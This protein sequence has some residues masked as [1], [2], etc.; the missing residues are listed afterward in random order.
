MNYNCE[1]IKEIAKILNEC[2]NYYDE[3]GR[4]LGNKCSYCEHW[5][6]TN[7]TCCSYNIKEA[8]ELYNAGYRKIPEGSVVLNR[9]EAQHYY[10]YKHIEPQIKGCLDRERKL[11]KQVKQERKETIKDS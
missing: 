3:Q 5:C 7:H 6:K 2:C 8:E 1:E 4:H 10:A 9:N 11:E